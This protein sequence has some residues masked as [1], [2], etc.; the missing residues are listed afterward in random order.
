MLLHYLG[1]R[2]PKIA[3]LHLNAVSSFADRNTKHKVSGQYWSDISLSQQML[4]VIKRVFDDFICLLAT[5]RMHAP[6]HGAR[7]TVQQ[8]VLLW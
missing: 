7:N 3:S 4:A 6:A 5:Q 8:F 2:K 1:N